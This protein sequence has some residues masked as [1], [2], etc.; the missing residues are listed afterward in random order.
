MSN[1][2]QIN[3]DYMDRDPVYLQYLGQARPQQAWLEMDRHGVIS[4]D[5]SGDPSGNSY[6]FDVA[7]GRTIRWSLPP[8]ISGQGLSDL[9]DEIRDDLE[10]VHREHET[11]HDGSHLRG[12]LSDEAEATARRIQNRIDGGDWHHCQH[13]DAG[14][15]LDGSMRDVDEFDAETVTLDDVARIADSII[16]HGDG[17]EPEPG[18]TVILD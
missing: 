8:E 3:I 7:Y 12:T 2:I 4:T 15:W 6:S 17:F 1:T 5:I 18:I 10:S 9:I 13:W 14:E 11:W 16:D